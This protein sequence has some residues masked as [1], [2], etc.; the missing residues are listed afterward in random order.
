MKNTKRIL[1]GTFLSLFVLSLGAQTGA[2]SL[3]IGGSS[4]FSFSADNQKYKS[5]DGDGTL[6]KGFSISLTPQFGYF[7]IDGL[8]VGLILDVSV[9]SFKDDGAEDSESYTTILAGPFVR[10]YVNIGDGMIKP[11]AEA[12]IGVG[13]QI[14]KYVDFEDDTQ[15][16][17]TG[18]F[19]YQFKIGAAA[20]LND[21]VSIDM[22]LGYSST[23]LKDKEDNDDN[24]KYIFGSFGLEVGISVIL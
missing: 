14:Y 15:K 24:E 17:K 20:F 21:N 5:D 11:F 18:V 8:A 23:T 1:L 3:L 2:G 6:G 22:G 7:V 12:A 9:E 10:Y 13:S 4:S 19:G 16:E